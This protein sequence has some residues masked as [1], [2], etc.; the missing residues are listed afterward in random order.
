MTAPCPP[1]SLQRPAPIGPTSQ[2]TQASIVLVGMMG[3]GK[4]TVG[5]HLAQ[6]LDCPF[7]DVDREIERAEQCSVADIFAQR[8]EGAFRHLERVTIKRLLKSAPAGGVQVIALGGGAWAQPEV[9][10]MVR[11]TPHCRSV[12]LQADPATLRQRVAKQQPTRPLLAGTDPEAAL[13]C[14]LAQRAAAYGEAEI[15]LPAQGGV[16]QILA[17]LLAKLADHPLMPPLPPIPGTP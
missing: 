15:H 9:R 16:E 11:A 8:G 13:E 5:R 12:W 2:A 6:Q 10:H 17:A 7:A 14:L 3:A 1:A 4:S